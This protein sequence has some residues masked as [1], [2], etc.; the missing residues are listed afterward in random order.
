MFVRGYSLGVTCGPFGS[1][2]FAY[3]PCELAYFR[4]VPL[5]I[6]WNSL[7]HSHLARGTPQDGLH[8]MS[9]G[10]NNLCKGYP[11]WI[12]LDFVGLAPILKGVRIP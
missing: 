8:P 5:K 2:W 10:F 9:S 12:H 6:Y 7:M 11:L 3:D 1:H 4:R